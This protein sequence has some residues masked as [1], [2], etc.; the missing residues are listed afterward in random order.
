MQISF[1]LWQIKIIPS[2]G[3]NIQHNTEIN[4]SLVLLLKYIKNGQI[5]DAITFF[6]YVNFIQS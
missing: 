4:P 3:D 5:T 1:F 2:S 6:N